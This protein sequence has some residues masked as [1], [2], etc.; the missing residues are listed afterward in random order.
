MVFFNVKTCQIN[1]NKEF[2]KYF[3]DAVSSN[4][5]Y[6][7]NIINTR[8]RNETNV[9]FRFYNTYGRSSHMMIGEENEILDTVNL[10]IEFD[11]WFIEGTDLD[12]A[13]P[14]VKDFIKKDVETLNDQGLNNVYI[15]NLMRKLETNFSF[16]DHIRFV[17]INNY[18]STYQTI[19]SNFE[20]LNELSVEERRHYIPEFMV[21]DKEDIIINEYFV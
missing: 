10:G 19:R 21:I 6:I 11:M 3:L 12:T 14:A 7:T 20:D 2:L 1:G 18:E 16:I 13:L 4:H 8:L 5:D 9:D 15:S 17:K